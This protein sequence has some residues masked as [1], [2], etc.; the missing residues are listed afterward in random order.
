VKLP[1]ANEKINAVTIGNNAYN[2][3][4]AQRVLTI[5]SLKNSIEYTPTVTAP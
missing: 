1:W 5:G 4:L 3:P 2:P